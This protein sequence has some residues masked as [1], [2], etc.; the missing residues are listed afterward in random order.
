MTRRGREKSEIG[1]GTKGVGQ[2]F[3][4]AAGAKGAGPDLS[5][6]A[7]DVFVAPVGALLVETGAGFNGRKQKRTILDEGEPEVAWQFVFGW[8]AAGADLDDRGAS[9]P[10]ACERLVVPKGL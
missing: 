4:G 8:D 7:K 6:V 5:G 9:R 3:E 2:R 1:A 10:A